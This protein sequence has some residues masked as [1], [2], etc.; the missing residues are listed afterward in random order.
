MGPHPEGHLHKGAPFGA[1]G[2]TDEMHTGFAGSTVAFAGVAADAT[3]NNIF[4]VG[5]PATILGHD[6]VQI[7]VA[8]IKGFSTVLAGVFISS[9]VNPSTITELFSFILSPY[10]QFSL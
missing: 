9:G 10:H 3:A 6:M 5:G 2:C 8:A 1:L 7:E 4:P